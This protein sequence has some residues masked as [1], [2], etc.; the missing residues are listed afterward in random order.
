MSKGG[1]KP[2][3]F[4]PIVIDGG[5]PPDATTLDLSYE[6]VLDLQRLRRERPDLVRQFAKAG[7]KCCQHASVELSDDE[8]IRTVWCADCGAELD[9]VDV[10][11]GYAGEERRFLIEDN[12]NRADSR[13]AEAQ[14]ASLKKQ[15]SAIIAA[16][17]RDVE[18]A[19]SP[20]TADTPLRKSVATSLAIVWPNL[21]DEDLRHIQQYAQGVMRRYE[22][23]GARAR[24]AP[25]AAVDPDIKSDG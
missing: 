24:S 17:R 4:E 16:M 23:P 6:P 12:A 1:K 22:F 3:G 8:A 15:R 19:G 20:L 2:K 13:H 25:L 14:L 10:L 21:S 7:V 11:R 5:A 9:A 18:K